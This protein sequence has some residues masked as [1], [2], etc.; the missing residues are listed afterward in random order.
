M[1]QAAIGIDVGGTKMAGGVVDA[2]GK[3]LYS[4]TVATPREFADLEREFVALV[5]NMLS[6][7]AGKAPVALDFAPVEVTGIGVAVPGSVNR[8]KGLAVGACNL[9]WQ[10][11]AI[12][13]LLEGRFGIPTRVENDADAA[14]LGALRYAPEAKGIQNFVFMTIGTGI[15]GGIILNGK[16]HGGQW[17]LAGEV[18][19][20]IVQPDGPL[21]NCGSRGCLEAL[22]SGTA[23]G[24]EGTDTVRKEQRGLLWTVYQENGQVTAADVTAAAEQG[25]ALAEEVLRQAARCLAIGML[26]IQRLLSPE[27]IIVGGGVVTK[28]DILLRYTKEAMPLIHPTLRARVVQVKGG[29]IS[30]VRGSAAIVWEEI[31]GQVI[32]VTQG[33]I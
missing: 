24:R 32:D 25:D 33:G 15:G 12:K 26:N 29:S 13:E 28:S 19:H 8:E 18:G 20:T 30:G 27:A 6:A 14:A 11:F 7:A 16:L 5:A 21:C 3:I 10:N 2:K 4:H 23:I 9:P 22:T 31:V 1:M 17:P